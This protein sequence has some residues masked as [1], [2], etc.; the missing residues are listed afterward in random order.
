MADT[1]EAMIVNVLV[2]LSRNESLYVNNSTKD[3]EQTVLDAITS[4]LCFNNCSSNGKCVQGI[5][6]FFVCLIN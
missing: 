1:V 2:E 6:F 5:C 3:G 4:R